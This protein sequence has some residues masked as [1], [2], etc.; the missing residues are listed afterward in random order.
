MKIKINIIKFLALLIF[1]TFAF[2]NIHQAK[3]QNSLLEVLTENTDSTNINNFFGA[4]FNQSDQN[5]KVEN[6]TSN[7]IKN[8]IPIANGYRAIVTE[9]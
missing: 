3:A 2:D 9:P 4:D 7:G 1:S 8:I 5:T 6:R